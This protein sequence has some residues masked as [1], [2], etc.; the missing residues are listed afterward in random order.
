MSTTASA[1]AVEGEALDTRPSL[2]EK[3]RRILDYLRS[4]AG[5]KTY[6][7]SR[8]IADD[9][10]LSAKEVGANMRPILDGDFD[11]TVEKWGYSSGTTWKV[12]V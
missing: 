9:L 7:K 3:Q 6:F 4:N 8:L 5:A 11:V 10:D 1:A 12:T 2:S